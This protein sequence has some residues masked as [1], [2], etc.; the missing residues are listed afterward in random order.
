MGYAFEDFKVGDTIDLGATPEDR[1]EMLAFARRLDP[2]RSTPI[3]PRRPTRCS[4]GLLRFTFVGMLGL[5][6]PGVPS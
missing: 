6:Q 4:A 2:N 3:R 1:S 5:R